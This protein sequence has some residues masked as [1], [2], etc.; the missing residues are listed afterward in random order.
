MQAYAS[1]SEIIHN[2]VRGVIQCRRG[3]GN[4]VAMSTIGGTI[5]HGITLGSPGYYSPLSITAAGYV[6]NNGTSFAITGQIGTVINSGTVRS[7]GTYAAIYLYTATL[8]NHGTVDSTYRGVD[9]R[10]LGSVNNTGTII[11]GRWGISGEHLAT[12]TNS[13]TVQSSGNG[14]QLFVGGAITNSAAIIGLNGLAISGATGTVD[15]TGTITASY[16]T[17][18]RLDSG[19]T[20]TNA[21]GGAILEGGDYVAVAINGGPGRIVNAGTIQG[22]V[23][24]AGDSTGMTVVNSGTII[25]T[26]G[27]AIAFGTGNDRLQLLPGALAI[28]G[29]VDGGGGA[30]KLEFL[31]AA[32]AGTLTG[33]GATFSGFHAATIDTGAAWTI[34]GTTT[35]ATG[36][37]LADLGTLIV[38]GSLTSGAAITAPQSTGLRLLPGASFTNLAGGALSLA[39]SNYNTYDPVIR[40]SAGGP[41]TITN[42]GTIRNGQAGIYLPAGG[43]ITNGATNTTTALI[44]AH[45]GVANGFGTTA[46][47]INY[48]TIIGN[49]A[50]AT[51]A[52][53]A[54]DLLNGIVTNGAPG[55]TAALLVGGVGVMF[56]ETLSV[57]RNFGTIHGTYSSGIG[58][59]IYY[60]RGGTVINGG[61][62]IGTDAAISFGTATRFGAVGGNLV[63]LYPGS[64]LIGQVRAPGPGNRLQLSALPGSAAQI[65]TISAIGTS[66]TGFGTI[67]VDPGAAWQLNGSSALGIGVTLSNAGTLITTGPLDITDNVA[68]QLLPGA[69]LRNDPG[70]TITAD[71]TVVPASPAV[72]GQ[73]GGAATIVNRGL[74]RGALGNGISLAGGGTITNS[75]TI[76]ATATAIAFGGTADS[77]LILESGYHLQGAVIGSPTAHTTAE[78]RGTVASPVTA[79]YSS[80]GLVNVGTL[81]FAPGATNAA[82]LVLTD[83]TTLPTTIAHFTA[84]HD[85]IDFTALDDTADNAVT[86]FDTITNRLTITA[87]AASVA[88]QLD[89]E[90]YAG[91]SFLALP[92]G[93]G[94]TA[95]QALAL[96]PPHIAGTTPNQG[97]PDQ[98]PIAPFPTL[99]ITDTS[100]PAHETVTV[101]LSTATDG[102]L[103][104]LAGGTFDPTAGV[105]TITG[106]PTAVSAALAGLVFTPNPHPAA[107]LQ[108]TGFT[109]AVDNGSGPVTDSSTQVTSVRQVLG[110]AVLPPGSIDVTVS[111]TGTTFPAPGAGR[112]GEA[113]VLAPTPGATF[114]LP[115]GDRAE[116]LGGT[117]NATFYDP[118]SLGA[119]LA[120]N[121]GNDRILAG[122]GSDTVITGTG[123]NS[124]LL[125]AGADF[126]ASSGNDLIVGAG[127]LAT[128]ATGTSN[129]AIFLGAGSTSVGTGAGGHS[130]VVAGSGAATI[131]TNGGTTIFLGT[132][133]AQVTTNGTDTVAAGA[134]AATINAAIGNPF[135]YG[136]TGSLD[137]IAG[138]GAATILG[139]TGALTVT[140][141]TGPTLVLARGPTLVDGGPGTATVV[142]GPSGAITVQGG[143][144]AGAYAG[145]SG[146]GNHIAGGSGAALIVGG[147]DGDVLA[148]GGSA[149]DTIAA[150][151]GAETILGGGSTGADFFYGGTG[152]TLIEPGAGTTQ[153]LAGTGSETII[154]G[155]GIEV[156]AFAS[157]RHAIAEIHGF[158]PTRQLIGLQGFAPG[159]AS[160]ALSGAVTT[161]GNE[162]LTLSDGTQIQFVGFTGL[163]AA[164]FV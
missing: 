64:T 142:G 162:R 119:L 159:A 156:F 31:S 160:T 163:T 134:G 94:G 5:N 152:S 131:T 29:L 52:H 13:G 76:A 117:A 22:Y 21:A 2:P 15:N 77:L 18:V 83:T 47:V 146:G 109:I 1:T 66:F 102:A 63:Q 158:D 148:A 93:S 95:V 54:L 44:Y 85:T 49:Y 125:G 123:A 104:N 136:G 58:V 147:G 153:I 27:T 121:A 80:L 71:G 45:D 43:T 151:S 55:S 132:G 17:G 157:G 30:D 108:T 139:A 32:S 100:A 122:T 48:G 50:G 10:S 81:A 57:L 118:G 51:G 23:G 127:G 46:S 67:T 79:T 24:I 40:G 88:L 129:A 26:S 86:H 115:T 145:G 16:G 75:G 73:A 150:G 106:S 149:S 143:A 36:T 120:G 96:T 38:A 91:L 110:L 61:T 90:S 114:A 39:A 4:G 25:G 42:L 89:A 33:T 7:T 135:L 60:G 87:G 69:Y 113:V 53:R 19:G 155:T 11:G 9:I 56:Q 62:I 99:A 103:S 164:S 41:S 128:I 12:I 65:G 126:V 112:I 84:P 154:A 124:V 130:T 97:V 105:Y 72:F 3:L 70:G 107:L 37:T 133:P 111:Q 144:G 35:L 138:A 74:I 28:T 8:I 34:A 6:S 140:G 137:V 98:R 92:D 116:F 161:G 101:S 82:T 78:L 59:D 20:I 141:G 14:I 68:L